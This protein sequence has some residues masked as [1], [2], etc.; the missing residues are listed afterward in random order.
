MEKRCLS[1]WQ[2]RKSQP[3]HRLIFSGI[4]LTSVLVSCKGV[5]LS[6]YKP[7]P[8]GHGTRDDE[9]CRDLA[10]ERPFDAKTLSTLRKHL[11]AIKAIQAKMK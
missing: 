7:W 9:T 4:Q 8:S 1:K 3:W 2:L 5:Q 10:A 6:R 11:D